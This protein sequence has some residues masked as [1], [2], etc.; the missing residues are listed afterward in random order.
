MRLTLAMLFLTASLGHAQPAEAVASALADAA[1]LPIEQAHRTRYLALWNI[2]QAERAEFSKVA[3]FWVNS[4]SRE[5][6][7]ISPRKVGSDLLAVDMGDYGWPQA[8]WEKLGESDPYFHVVIEGAGFE[9]IDEVE[10]LGTM[11][12]VVENGAVVQRWKANG[13]TRKTGKKIKKPTTSTRK[14]AVAPWCGPSAQALTLATGSACPVV[15]A[16]WFIVQTAQAQDRNG[17]GYYDFLALGKTEADFQ[18]LIGAD[19]KAAQRLHKEQAAVVGRSTVTLNNRGIERFQAITGSYWRTNDYKA[20][21]DTRNSLR[22]L[23][24]DTVPP[25]DA[26]EQYGTLPN[27]LFAF[28]LANDKG[29]RQNAAP[30]SIASDSKS[31]SPDRRVH[32]GV[33]CVRCHVPGIQPVDDWSRKVY[34]GDIQ[35]GSPDY[36]RLRRLRQLYLSDLGRSIKRDQADYSEALTRLNGLTSQAN[37]TA[38]ARVHSA[39]ADADVTAA[40]F[41]ADMGVK[42]GAFK[43]AMLEYAKRKPL[44]PLLLGMVAR[45]IPLRREHAEELF[46]VAQLIMAGAK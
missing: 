24:G 40:M 34:T 10:E 28:F 31:S 15:R 39:Y 20:S 43:A 44:D 17:T 22:L 37:A 45:D 38:F 19:V 6:E 4:L 14:S 27:G 1:R 30:D 5:S 12:N 41:A 32:V 33:S 36:D 16:D 9:L 29:E 18:L 23:D 13:E 3:A 11:Q 2:P 21:N 7:L 25:R 35:L 42:P 8:T 46:S 26:S